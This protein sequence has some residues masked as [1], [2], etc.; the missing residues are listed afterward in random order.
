MCKAGFFL[1]RAG[2]GGGGGGGSGGGGGGGGGGGESPLPP[3]KLCVL[4]VT[5]MYTI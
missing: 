3:F 5:F 1:H 2:G 4:Y